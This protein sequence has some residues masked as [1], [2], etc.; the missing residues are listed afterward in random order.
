MKAV[1]Y[2]VIY[3][4]FLQLKT[5]MKLV[6]AST[7]PF[8]KSLLDRLNLAYETDSPDIDESPLANESIKDMVV[9][10]SEGKARAVAQ[11][12]PDSLIIGSDQSAVLNNQ[13]LTKPGGYDKAFQQ[14]KEA[15]GQKIVF[16]TGLCLLNSKTGKTQTA[17]I[18]YTVVFKNLTNQQISHYLKQ[19]E[20]YNCAGSFKS[21]ALGIALFERFEGEDPNA[22]I[23]LPLIKLVEMLNNE[24]MPPL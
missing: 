15:S 1:S 17:C 2:R 10:L 20:P 19:E 22:L 16:Q 3:A 23:G 6:L 4:P 9:R 21:E 24:N 11:S 18:P 13:P 7:S 5:S 8:R 14:L 12:H